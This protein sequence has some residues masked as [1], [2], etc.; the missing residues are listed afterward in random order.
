MPR[1]LDEQTDEELEWALANGQL[2]DV[3]LPSLKKFYLDVGRANRRRSKAVMAGSDAQQPLSPW[4]SWSLGG[5]L[6]DPE[7]RIVERSCDF[8]F[9]ARQVAAIGQHLINPPSRDAV[10]YSAATSTRKISERL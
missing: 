2:D 9:R 1:P 8:Q 3:K 6:E 10:S 7:C 4:R 5:F